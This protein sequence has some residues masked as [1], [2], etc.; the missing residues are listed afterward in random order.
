MGIPKK[1][2][3][4]QLKK[5]EISKITMRDPKNN[6]MSSNAFLKKPLLR[7]LVFINGK[8]FFNL[9]QNLF[10]IFKIHGYLLKMSTF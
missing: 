10:D 9:L 1:S 7:F 4:T 6:M 3:N 5:R 8:H 2:D